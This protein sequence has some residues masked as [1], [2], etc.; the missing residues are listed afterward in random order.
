MKTP[1][2]HTSRQGHRARMRETLL[3]ESVGQRTERIADRDLLEVLLYY[4]IPQRDTSMIAT[5]LIRSFR[6]LR[7]VLDAPA[8]AL[9]EI[10][11][12]GTY[13]G[14]FLRILPIVFRRYMEQTVLPHTFLSSDR[15]QIVQYLR[16]QYIGATVE[17][18]LLLLFN[19][20]GEFLDCVTM[21]FGSTFNVDM[22]KRDL[23]RVVSAAQA[24]SVILSHRHPGSVAAPSTEDIAATRMVRTVLN[25]MDVR[26]VDHVIFS[27]SDSNCFM[28]DIPHLRCLFA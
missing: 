13:T 7:G 18:M 28:S 27:S 15:T 22:H 11:G 6:T 21:G 24:S 9:T 2:D 1:G 3:S 10:D 23:V 25:S 19:A 8:E 14:D 26:L 20:C 17:Q 4:S 16:V 5:D 12:V